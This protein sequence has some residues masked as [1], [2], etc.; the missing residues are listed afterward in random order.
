MKL[1]ARTTYLHI[2]SPRSRLVGDIFPDEIVVLVVSP[3]VRGDIERP[4]TP[5]V[6]AQISCREKRKPEVHPR[7]KPSKNNRMEGMRKELY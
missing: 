6:G 5:W 1:M 4:Q 2:V 3:H 7:H